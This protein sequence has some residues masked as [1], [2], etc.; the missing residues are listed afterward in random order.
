MEAIK[1]AS[2]SQQ[3]CEQITL[4]KMRRKRATFIIVEQ[5]MWYCSD[6]GHTAKNLTCIWY[7]TTYESGNVCAFWLQSERSQ[8]V[9]KSEE[10]R[11]F[12]CIMVTGWRLQHINYKLHWST[13]MAEGILLLITVI[14]Y[15]TKADWLLV[16]RSLS[17]NG[18]TSSPRTQ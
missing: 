4:M 3:I 14:V 18:L 12:E 6:W 8:R 17:P 7:G 5:Y 15:Q 2:T 9:K 10:Q 16:T 11:H 1:A 13:L